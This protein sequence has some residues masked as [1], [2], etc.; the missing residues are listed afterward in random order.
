[1]VLIRR[2]FAKKTEYEKNE[3]EIEQY[4]TTC[5]IRA[6]TKVLNQAEE[7]FKLQ[8]F[9][10]IDDLNGVDKDFDA[11]IE[12]AKKQQSKNIAIKHIFYNADW[13]LIN[14]NIIEKVKFYKELTA[15]TA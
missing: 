11:V 10:F 1:M 7:D 5:K 8:L 13:Y 15:I 2:E 12:K 4:E 3:I 9:E 14:N 6:Q